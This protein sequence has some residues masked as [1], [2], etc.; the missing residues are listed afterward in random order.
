MEGELDCSAQEHSLV[1]QSTQSR[2]ELMLYVVSV[3]W[4]LACSGVSGRHRLKLNS[5]DFYFCRNHASEAAECVGHDVRK[6]NHRCRHVTA[7]KNLS[8]ILLEL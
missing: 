1:E 3:T 5:N 6:I 4:L 7:V 8:N 2:V